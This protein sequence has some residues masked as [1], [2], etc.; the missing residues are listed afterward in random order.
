MDRASA[1]IAW[2]DSYWSFD[3]DRVTPARKGIMRE[4]PWPLFVDEHEWLQVVATPVQLELFAVGF[5]YN[6]GVI[7][8]LD[9]VLS[10]RVC[11]EP[12]AI[13]DVRL[14]H[15]V[16]LPTKRTLTSG[17]GGGTTFADLAATR[18]PLPTTCAWTPDD[19]YGAMSGLLGAVAEEYRAFGGFHS[20]ALSPGGR[21]ISFVANDVGRHNTIDKLAGACLLYG[22]DPHEHMLV[23]TGR[24]SS[25]MIGKAARLG[26]E[27]VISR[28]SPTATTVQ[29]ARAW[30]ITVIGYCRGR[31]MHVYSAP[32]RILVPQP[33]FVPETRST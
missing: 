7:D 8:S 20:S 17:C 11:D 14:T 23:S 9:E 16:I 25:E 15:R 10:V 13:I 26:I 21:Q 1:A 6:E 32:E 18:E 33:A 4:T 24:I 22:I 2:E 29:L 5:L 27:V 3:G 31:R 28:N 12:E 19:V 30:N